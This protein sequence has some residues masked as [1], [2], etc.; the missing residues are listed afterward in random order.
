MSPPVSNPPLGPGEVSFAGA[1]GGTNLASPARGLLSPGEPL[2]LHAPRA[3]DRS[4][5]TDGDHPPSSGPP[6]V[7][8][9]LPSYGPA[10]DAAGIAAPARAPRS[11][12]AKHLL[13]AVAFGAFVPASLYLTLLAL[14]G[15]FDDP[16]PTN[17]ALAAVLLAAY[18]RAVSKISGMV[19]ERNDEPNGLGSLAGRVFGALA[20]TAAL[21]VGGA[22]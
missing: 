13:A 19:L 11:G 15:G 16:A 22:L 20:V 18:S 5:W 4:P 6:S 1:E 9:Q 21:W 10:P 12:D 17:V 7:P 14:V 3:L 2:T 8:A